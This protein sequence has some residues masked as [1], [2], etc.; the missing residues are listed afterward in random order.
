MQ[1]RSYAIYQQRSAP[2]GD[3]TPSPCREKA[4]GRA[5]SAAARQALGGE[6]A[7]EQVSTTQPVLQQRRWQL[8][9]WGA[10]VLSLPAVRPLTCS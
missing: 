8:V 6:P 4:P 5:A 9:Q 2:A 3:R 10:E 1:N 7:C